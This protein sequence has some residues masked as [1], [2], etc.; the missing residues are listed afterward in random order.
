MMKKFLFATMLIVMI[1]FLGVSAAKAYTFGTG[2]FQIDISPNTP[3][4]EGEQGTQKAINT[5]YDAIITVSGIAFIILF[6]ISGVMYL[7]AA[8]NEETA[9]KAR[10]MMIDA[11]IGLVIVLAA[12]AIGTWIIDRLKGTNSSSTTGST[13]TASGLPTPSSIKTNSLQGASPTPTTIK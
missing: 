13:S 7:T 11:V 9:G 3:Y 4:G 2:Q 1:S 12:W 5:I 8:G 6:L 10:K